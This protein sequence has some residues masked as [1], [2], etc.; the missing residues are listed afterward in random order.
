[1]SSGFA[2]RRVLPVVELF[3]HVVLGPVDVEIQ[4]IVDVVDMGGSEDFF[5]RV[6]LSSVAQADQRAVGRGV[7]GARVVQRT[8]QTN[9]R[10]EATVV[11]KSPA[12]DVMVATQ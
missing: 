2:S 8:G 1:M 4:A 5:V 11:P 3:D 7:A 6:L 10:Y 9:V 12:V